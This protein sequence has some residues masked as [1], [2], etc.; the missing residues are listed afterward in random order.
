MKVAMKTL[1]SV[2]SAGRAAFPAVPLELRRLAEHVAL[3]EISAQA[4]L[5]RPY[6]IYLAVAAAAGSLPA[7]E[8]IERQHLSPI[9]AHLRKLR[10]AADVI[11]EACQALRVRMLVGPGPQVS[12]YNG[13]IPLGDWLRVA[14]LRL[15]LDLVRSSGR[16]QALERVH[17]ASLPRAAA[18]DAEGDL[19]RRR[20]LPVYQRA[21]E[22]ALS[23]LPDR[24]RELLSLRYLGGFGIDSIA[25][26]H[27]V[28]RGTIARRLSSARQALRR[29]IE[30]LVSA[31]LGLR[32]AA[33][34]DQLL[35]LV[36]SDL[37]L[38]ERAGWLG[39][40][41]ER[42]RRPALLDAPVAPTISVTEGEAPLRGGDIDR[43]RRPFL[44]GTGR[45]H[46]A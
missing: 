26:L 27:G 19:D 22:Q 36:R 35:E 31:R 24:T 7:V 2:V 40:R 38:P 28:H 17:T 3:R 32:S 12:R 29:S 6:D 23:S 9:R 42:D 10:L 34:F 16:R 15:A 25:P 37:H 4:L 5:T 44:A 21:L 14:A 39:A 33:D 43:R 46:V 30:E 13:V 20:L 45:W 11:D 1:E 41:H 8:L 18:S